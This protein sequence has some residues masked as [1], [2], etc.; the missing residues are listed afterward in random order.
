VKVALGLVLW[1]QSAVAFAATLAP[2]LTNGELGVRIDALPFPATLS[3][4]LE[5]GLTNRLYVRVSL[6][7]GQTL[8]QMRTVEIAIRYNLWEETFTVTRTM[9]GAPAD[10]QQLASTTEVNASLASLRL[11]RLFAARTLPANRELLLRAELLLNPIGREKLRMIRKWV[12]ENSTPD[13][14]A[15]QGI[16]TSNTIFNRIFEQYADGSDVAAEWRVDVTSPPF[17]PR[18]LTHEGR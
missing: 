9:E 4:E 13:V 6:L 3:R 14:G 10:V 11:P 8:V 17:R 12:A 18:S 16:S 5:S 7:D 2:T 15:D 1:L